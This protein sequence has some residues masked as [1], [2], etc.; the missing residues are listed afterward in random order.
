M[1]PRLQ[2][3]VRVGDVGLV[4]LLR[5]GRT[6]EPRLA[7]LDAVV[8]RSQSGIGEEILNGRLYVLEFGGSG[9]VWEITTPAAEPTGRRT[10]A[11]VPR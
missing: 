5:G 9:T 11:N 1:D 6:R 2:V 7:R 4:V 3:G 10:C 8:E